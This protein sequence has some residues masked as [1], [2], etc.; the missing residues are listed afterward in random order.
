MGTHRRKGPA[1]PREYVVHP[2]SDDPAPQQGTPASRYVSSGIGGVVH[3]APRNRASRNNAGSVSRD[4]EFCNSCPTL[5]CE[6][7]HRFRNRRTISRGDEAK[8]WWIVRSVARCL[9]DAAFPPFMP[10]RGG[11]RDPPTEGDPSR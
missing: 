3:Q 10:S 9:I 2:L 11:A 5:W 8:A 6:K 1:L 4:R 7:L